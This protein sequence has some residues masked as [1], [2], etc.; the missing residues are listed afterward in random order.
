MAGP[1]GLCRRNP[2]GR[3]RPVLRRD[4][5]VGTGKTSGPPTE[6]VDPVRSPVFPEIE[7]EHGV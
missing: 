2:K 6:A 7:G 1:E 4:H 5:R 3:R